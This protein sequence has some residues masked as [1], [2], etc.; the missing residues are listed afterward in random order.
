MTK[1]KQPGSEI[2]ALREE[3]RLHNYR[4]HVLDDPVASDAEYDRLLRRLLELEA[5]YPELVTADSPTRRVGAPP[6]TRF[7]VVKRDQPMMSLDNVMNADAFDE[8]RE[9]LVREVGEKGA[10][11]YVCEPKVDGVAVELVYENGTLVLGATRGDGVNGE[12]ITENIKTVRSIPLRLIGENSPV[13]L[14]VRGEVYM[15]KEAFERLNREQADAGEKIYANPRN[16]TAGSLKQLD[17]SIT[18]K[19]NL[20]FVAYG[21]GRVQVAD[22]A[23][24]P[25]SQWEFLAAVRKWGIRTNPLSRLCRTG[26][27]VAAFYDELLKGRSKVPYEIDGVVIKANKFDVQR[28]AGVRSRSPRWAIAWKFPAEQEKTRILGIDIQVGR[29][30]ALTPVARLEPVVVGGVTVSNATLHNEDE[31]RKKGVL[32]GDWVFVR[33]AGDVI[34]EVV[35]PI[36]DLRTGEET[37]FVMPAHCPVCNTKVVRPEG[38]AVVRC[39][40]LECPGQVKERI[41]HFASRDA[42]DIEGMGEKLVEQLVEEEL[43]GNPAD[44]YGLRIDDLLPLER[45]AEKSAENVIAGI[46]RSKQTTLPRLLYALGIRNVGTTVSDVVSE[47][48]PR[49]EALAKASIEDIS[50]IDGVGPVIAREIKHFF[51]DS[52]NRKMVEK[53]IKA[54]VT[55]EE[56]EQSRTMEFEGELFVFTGSL[57]TLSRTQAAAAVKRRGAKIASTVTKKTTI[58]VAGEE[59]GSK[60]AKAEKLGIKIIDEAAFLDMIREQ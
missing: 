51:D 12:D 50:N 22:G 38:E 7:E 6:Q 47:H 44:L 59:A 40:N 23:T 20:T 1:K 48:F 49:I 35:A 32:V 3:I 5:E 58:V 9:R 39:P 17:P 26:D 37:E 57:E 43:V 16:L 34:P 56:I 15:T 2:E 42:M 10:E 11:D 60:H 41:R 46:E 27:D 53:I 36:P 24:E 28:K 29:T 25:A 45:L 8:W 21:S 55:C 54:G 14:N 52:Q 13:H 31:V 19:R 30:G 33:R 4:Y 18:A